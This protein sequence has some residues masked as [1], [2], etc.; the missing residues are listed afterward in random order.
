MAVG[1]GD[2]RDG[3]LRIARAL[4]RL[5]APS[6]LIQAAIA[7]LTA[8]L[9]EVTRFTARLDR[10]RATV[11]QP[12]ALVEVDA[13]LQALFAH[14][15]REWLRYRRR[16]R[17]SRRSRPP[18]DTTLVDVHRFV[19][20]W[21][22]FVRAET[23][24]TRLDAARV[25]V[26]FPPFISPYFQRPA[27]RRAVR[28]LPGRDRDGRDRRAQVLEWLAQALCDVWEEETCRP[29]RLRLG[30]RGV[31]VKAPGG[32]WT[33]SAP[34]QPAVPVPKGTIIPVMA[35]FR[36]DVVGLYRFL[37]Q[38]TKKRAANYLL[39]VV[40]YVPREVGKRRPSAATAAGDT[41]ALVLAS[42][43]P[44]GA[45]AQTH[46]LSASAR[47]ECE[48]ALQRLLADL[49]DDELWLA[50]ML[51][52]RTPRSAIAAAFGWSLPATYTRIHRFRQKHPVAM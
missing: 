51:A 26:S 16:S 15:L 10:I 20:A 22:R 37:R 45:E 8:P 28:A 36:L 40:G 24:A 11:F 17:R 35:V 31:Y 23:D 50:A 43:V 38:R 33:R 5:R 52:L 4:D 30:E 47:L 18:G 7:G 39:Q 27:A 14:V 34:D 1:G 46:V 32:G 19:V 44:T 12:A 21:V 25:M 49:T 3:L 2:G 41:T 48:E 42:Q 29:G 9:A 13:K 6:D